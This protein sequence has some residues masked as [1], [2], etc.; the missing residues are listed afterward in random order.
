MK[1]SKIV[2]AFFCFFFISYIFILSPILL[3]TQ[4][5]IKAEVHQKINT[6]TFDS[7]FTFLFFNESEFK[8]ITWIDESELVLNGV[9][10]DVVHID[11]KEN[12]DHIIKVF[13]DTKETKIVDILVDSSNQNASAK[14]C[15]NFL[16]QLF[17]QF[18][19]ISETLTVFYNFKIIANNFDYLNH[20]SFTHSSQISKPPKLA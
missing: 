3:W 1:N 17:S 14:K 6:T 11:K 2:I 8:A 4:S 15:M 16:F 20:Y 18:H 5:G 13:A 10:Y 12:G 9:L 19:S 7:D